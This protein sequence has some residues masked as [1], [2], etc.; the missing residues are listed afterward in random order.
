VFCVCLFAVVE[1]FGGSSYEAMSARRD[2]FFM[3]V[4]KK[5]RAV[6]AEEEE[7]TEKEQK[8]GGGFRAMLESRRSEVRNADDDGGLFL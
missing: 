2:S 5:P 7:S 1:V 3:P 6:E 4:K 8:S